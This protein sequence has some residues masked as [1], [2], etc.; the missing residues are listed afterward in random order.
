MY[1]LERVADFDEGMRSG[2]YT[3]EGAYE[4]WVAR[5]VEMRVLGVAETYGVCGHVMSVL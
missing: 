5:C 2:V 3:Q 1:F 4:E